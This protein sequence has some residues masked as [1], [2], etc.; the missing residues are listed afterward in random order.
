MTRFDVLD[1]DTDTRG[2]LKEIYRILKSGGLFVI[3][4]PNHKNVMAYLCEQ[5]WDWWSVPDHVLHFFLAFY[6]NY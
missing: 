6:L 2:N 1:D 4:A 3:Q 5:N